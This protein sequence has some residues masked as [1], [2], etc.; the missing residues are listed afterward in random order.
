[1]VGFTCVILTDN[2]VEVSTVNCL[3][4]MCMYFEVHTSRNDGTRVSLVCGSTPR[5]LTT[6]PIAVT[7][8]WEKRKILKALAIQRGL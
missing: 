6:V 5:P 4:V 7:L 8:C 1:M 2:P 3:H